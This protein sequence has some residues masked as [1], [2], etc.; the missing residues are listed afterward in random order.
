MQWLKKLFKITPKHESE[1]TSDAFSL[2]DDSFRANQAII[3]GVQFTATLQIRTPLSVL[4]HHGEIYEGPPSEA[5]KYGSQRD[6][7]WVF[8]TDLEDEESSYESHHA[9]DIGPVKPSYYLPFLIEFRSIVE[10]SFDHDEQIQKLYQLSE[11]S[12]DFKAIWQKLTSHYD[13]FPHSYFYSQ[14]T[15]LPGVG[16]KTAQALY[17]KGFKNVE[18]IKAASISELCKVPGLGKRS[19]E[20]I[21]GVSE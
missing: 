12:K 18:Q 17:E 5:P 9:S 13:D 1:P 21:M 16:L 2:N 4:K 7:I 10:S 3:K 14:F 19:A 15:A 11:C 20:R 8:V 6:G